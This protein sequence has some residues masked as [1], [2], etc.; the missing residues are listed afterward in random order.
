MECGEL[1]VVGTRRH[2]SV[3][4]TEGMKRYGND[5]R[6]MGSFYSYILGMGVTP[7]YNS[8][9]HHSEVVLFLPAIFQFYQSLVIQS[10]QLMH[11]N[12]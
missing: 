2:D 3:V 12:E 4:K 6:V 1:V 7:Q 8:V 11:L 10:N 9:N 5:L